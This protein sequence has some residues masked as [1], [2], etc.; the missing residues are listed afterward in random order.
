MGTEVHSL[1]GSGH[2][3]QGSSAKR[4]KTTNCLVSI[5]ETSEIN[6]YCLFGSRVQDPISIVISSPNAFSFSHFPRR[7]S[8]D[9]V[10]SIE[11]KVSLPA[12]CFYSVIADFSSFQSDMLGIRV[13]P[14][15]G[16][17][18]PFT[19]RQMPCRTAAH[20]NLRNGEY[21]RLHLVCRM[22]TDPF[23]EGE[24]VRH[25]NP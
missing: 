7:V 1:P 13:N 4:G 12:R 6:V 22:H 19:Q 17:N 3:P 15:R 20:D 2:P 9:H 25:A 5:H 21:P 24:T 10:L 8:N 14:K 16:S 23:P 11:G 18:K